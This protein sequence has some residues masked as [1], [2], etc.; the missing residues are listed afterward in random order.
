MTA[1]SYIVIPPESVHYIHVY[2]SPVPVMNMDIF[3]PNRDE[4]IE[5]YNG[6]LKSSK[7]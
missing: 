2:D 7:A 5:K 3:V 4:Y 6:F 1:G